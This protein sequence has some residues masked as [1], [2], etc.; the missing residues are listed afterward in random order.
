[1][2]AQ[3][4]HPGSPSALPS[5]LGFPRLVLSVI[6]APSSHWFITLS[7]PLVGPTKNSAHPT[8]LLLLVAD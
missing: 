2:A 6:S 8:T 5:P 7:L 3:P 1:M 4:T